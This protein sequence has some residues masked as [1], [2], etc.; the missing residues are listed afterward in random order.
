MRSFF[1]HGSH[2]SHESLVVIDIS[3]TPHK[4]EFEKTESL[5]FGIGNFNELGGLIRMSTSWSLVL[6]NRT[7]RTPLAT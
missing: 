7:S 1:P 3:N 2:V 6:I 4:R 5:F